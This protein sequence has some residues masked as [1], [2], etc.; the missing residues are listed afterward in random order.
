MPYA[1]WVTFHPDGE[2]RRDRVVFTESGVRFLESGVSVG[3]T[4]ISSRG[5]NRYLVLLPEHGW[6]EMET[7][8]PYSFAAGL[9]RLAEPGHS[10]PAT[11]PAHPA[12]PQ[13]PAPTPAP[14]P[15]PRH[16]PG[17]EWKHYEKSS[18]TTALTLGII[19]I[20]LG[21]SC[22]FGFL[23]SPFAWSIGNTE[24][25]AIDAG[26]RDP[27]NRGNANAGR[28]MGMVGTILLIVGLIAL[29]ILVGIGASIGD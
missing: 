12:P 28:I 19:G 21:T 6:V 22:G 10:P 4:S 2:A 24:V 23:V 29:L 1:L 14:R 11:D 15:M 8:D 7:D 16:G 25:R 26:R 17:T 9:D 18:A 3:P 20:V 27:V 5:G 13:V